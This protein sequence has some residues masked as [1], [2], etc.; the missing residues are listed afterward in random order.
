MLKKSVGYDKPLYI[1]PFDHRNTFTKALFGDIEVLNLNQ[2]QITEIRNAK[3]LVYEG[4]KYGITLG[5]PKEYSAILVDEQFGDL[6]IK[7][8]LKEKILT[9]VCTEKTGQEEFDFEY[10]NKFPLHINKYN[11]DFVKVLIRYNPEGDGELNKRQRN[12]LKILSDFCTENNYKFLFEMLVPPTAQQSPVGKDRYETEMRSNLTV[13]AIKEIQNARIEVDVWKI[14]GMFARQDYVNVV[15]QIKSGGRNN[16]G[17]IILGKADNKE[18]VKHWLKTGAGLDG[19][20]GFAVGRT[21][22]LDAIIK[23]HKNIIDRETAIKQI[24][25]NYYEFY[26]IFTK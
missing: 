12:K 8:S 10:G 19:V 25:N 24:G 15:K 21:V 26:R 23:Q 3:E 2:E 4:A 11:P 20:L 18:H 22:F 1:L 17:L 6:V 7:A 13:R 9:A 14:E 16:V 5:I